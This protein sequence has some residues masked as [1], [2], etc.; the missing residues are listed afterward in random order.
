[1]DFLP[2]PSPQLYA[3]PSGDIWVAYYLPTAPSQPPSSISLA[4]AFAGTGTFVLSAAPKLSIDTN[5]GAIVTA[6]TAAINAFPG[7]RAIAWLLNPSAPAVSN[8]ALAG[9]SATGSTG[10]INVGLDAMLVSNNLYLTM[11][12][13]VQLTLNGDSLV[14]TPTTATNLSFS[15]A[16]A[17][18]SSTIQSATLWFSGGSAGSVVFS[19]F[20]KRSDLNN[21]LRWG[22]Q[23]LYGGSGKVFS[24]WYPLADGL[25]PNAADMLGFNVSIDPSDPANMRMP[26][27]SYLAFTGSNQ[28]NSST[29]L[30]S[31]YRTAYGDVVN[32][33]PIGQP[34]PG[35]QTARLTLSIGNPMAPNPPDFVFG[36][37]GDFILSLAAPKDGKQSL[38]LCGLT[39]TET[40]T[41]QAG[42]SAN[43]AA[44]DRLRFTAN[45]AAYAASYPP[46]K[47]NTLGPPIDLT[48]SP[49]DNT[50]RTAWACPINPPATAPNIHYSAQ[51]KG[52]SLFGFD[53]VISSKNP[54]LLGLV[55]PG[56]LLTGAAPFPVMAYALAAVDGSG[57]TFDEAAIGAVEQFAVAPTRRTVI[58]A[59]ANS[60]A[61]PPAR[62]AAGNGATAPTTTASGLLATI[63][64]ADGNLTSVI[65]GVN[66]Q[67]D[68]AGP[69]WMLF[70]DPSPKLQ[71]A[72]QTADLFLVAANGANLGKPAKSP[73]ST[74]PPA[75]DGTP[76]FY[77]V[78][79]V[80]DWEITAQVG[81][82]NAYGDYNNIFIVKKSKGRL[83]D[84]VGKPDVWTQRQDFSIPGQDPSEI[85]VLSQWLASYIQDGIDQWTKAKNPYFENFYN[86]ATNPAWTG[87]VI[88]KASLTELPAN[89]DGLLSVINPTECFAHHFGVTISPV[90]AGDKTISIPTSSSIFELIYY[91][92]PGF[93]PPV[94]AADT[95]P[96]PPDSTPY[97]FQLL[98]LKALFDNTAVKAFESLAQL[99][100]GAFFEDTVE[101]MQT[102]GNI[103]NTIL[104]QGS[105]QKRGTLATFLLDSVDDNLF[106]LNSNVI[107]KVEVTK[108]QFNTV[109]EHTLRFDLWGY[110]DFD[111][112]TGTAADKTTFPFD[113]FG[114]GYQGDPEQIRHGLSFSSLSIIE[115]TSQSPK[116]FTFSAGK[117]AFNPSPPASTPRPGSLYQS[118]ALQLKG[119]LSGDGQHDPSTQ[120][121]LTVPTNAPLSGVSGQPWYALQF[122]LKM[123]TAGALASKLGLT[124]GLIVAWAPGTPAGATA[125]S[126]IVGLQ[127][128]GVAAKSKLLSL[129]GVLALSIGAMRLTYDIPPGGATSR[130]WVLWLTDIA[131]KF[132]GLLKIPPNG[133]TS[134]ACFG[135]PD[136]S[137]QP[138]AVGWYAVY[139][140]DAPKAKLLVSAAG[141]RSEY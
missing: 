84:L 112:L 10:R 139:N 141:G 54:G 25:S 105:Y 55:D 31:G 71:Q 17:P 60:R 128:P 77:N 91:I 13:N 99:T 129:E 21:S 15:G 76:T 59:P 138:T 140:Q 81:Q 85:P 88:L 90:S 126:A 1:V 136:S 49:L 32:L 125:Y 137:G 23:M 4:E 117:M 34:Q 82:S 3:A 37:E 44:G 122:D 14:L 110:L 96:L 28:D 114:F 113:A 108:A 86:I 7:D 109:D 50:Y 92:K 12:G 94:H 43:P 73:S 29:V 80:D 115:D 48:A 123:G 101:H 18:Q 133:A 26:D 47:A 124:A 107:N 135:N 119:L 16:A 97:D 132:L 53:D 100:L 51:P 75:P 19:T 20:I 72:L 111:V 35:E 68:E 62:L 116:V 22:F 57:V 45:C 42:P 103:Y 36:P 70:T 65:L 63:D 9:I 89:L 30:A 66:Y 78:M 33:I 118:F 106:F 130:Y 121:Y 67:A 83:I 39:P 27:R 74:T 41:F 56:Y 40:L 87:I 46:A 120:N 134:F 127:L 38:L 64:T 52:S 131:L 11:G 69:L 102:G 6:I 95:Q 93:T 8:I 24:Q 61:H 104:L 98:T 2:T 5:A 58:G 79:A